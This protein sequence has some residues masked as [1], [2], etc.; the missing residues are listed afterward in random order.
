MMDSLIHAFAGAGVVSAGYFVI[1]AFLWFRRR[2]A[3]KAE[4]KEAI[5]NDAERV[6][7]QEFEDRISAIVKDILERKALPAPE[8]K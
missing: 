4:T 2:L 8:E 7:E 3:D 6:K 1:Q 5:A